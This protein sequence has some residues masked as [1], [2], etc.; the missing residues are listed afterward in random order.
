MDDAE[1]QVP[2][3]NLDCDRVEE[4]EDA[5]ADV[6]AHEPRA[7]DADVVWYERRLLEKLELAQLVDRQVPRLETYSTPPSLR[8]ERLQQH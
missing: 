8:R 1:I 6:P 2:L 4:E 3:D 7:L 5:R